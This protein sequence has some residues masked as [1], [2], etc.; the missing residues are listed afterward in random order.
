M[1][2]LKELL[3]PIKAYMGE[4]EDKKTEVVDGLHA[5]LP[6]IAQ[7]FIDKGAGLGKGELKKQLKAAKDEAKALKEKLEEVE[8]ERDEA[9]TK[10]PEE[11][12]KLQ[13]EV[14]KLKGQ[15]ESAKGETVAQR[16]ARK[17]DR[18]NADVERFKK[19]TKPGL[20]G[21]VQLGYDDDLA[22]AYRDRL[23][24]DEDGN[25]VVKQI[26]SDAVYTPAKNQDALELLAL[27]AVKRAPAWARLAGVDDGGGQGGGS[28]RG[29]DQVTADKI[30]EEK[31]QGNTYR[32]TF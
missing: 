13:R 2:D 15:L 8:A 9:R 14:D 31:L 28:G 18:L 24:E 26:G 30:V 22:R 3:A 5:E 4:D 21:G 19:Y 20:P 29:G 11:V 1:P 17:V 23:D 27:D 7:L 25:R 32:G 12:Q 16:E 10:S 6:D